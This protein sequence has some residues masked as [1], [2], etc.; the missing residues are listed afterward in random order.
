MIE[1][2]TKHGGIQIVVGVAAIV[3]CFLLWDCYKV[4]RSPEFKDEIR[5][6]RAQRAAKKAAR[7]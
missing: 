6:L 5:R 1:A 4:W 3:I 2:I 7:R